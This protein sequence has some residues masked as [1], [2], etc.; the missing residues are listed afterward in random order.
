MVVLFHLSG[1]EFLCVSIEAFDLV[2]TVDGV[3]VS[4]FPFIVFA[5]GESFLDDVPMSHVLAALVL[6]CLTTLG[7]VAA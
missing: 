2:Q 3:I 1:S 5:A 6:V 7:G 4:D